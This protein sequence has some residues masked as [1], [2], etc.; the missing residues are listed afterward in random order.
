[1]RSQSVDACELDTRCTKRG[2]SDR[3]TPICICTALLRAPDAGSEGSGLPLLVGTMIVHLSAL[4]P[5]EDEATPA[6]ANRAGCVLNMEFA[7]P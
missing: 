3:L 6:M 7:F 2:Q 5:P 4:S 1:M